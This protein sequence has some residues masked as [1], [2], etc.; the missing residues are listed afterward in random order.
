MTATAGR[1]LGIIAQTMLTMTG[2][3]TMLS[4]SRWAGD[5]GSYR[6]IQRFFATKI[7]WSQLLVK[8]FQTHLFNAEHDYILAGDETVVSKSGTETFGID[9]YFSGL[10]GKVIRGLSFFVF[11]L[12]DTTERKSSPLVVRQIV[13]SEAEKKLLKERRKK[14]PK[15]V[16][17][18]KGR[19]KGSLNKDKNELKLSPELWRIN[20]LL[21]TLV[22][23]LRE[24]VKI[25]YLAMDGH[26][27]HNQAV[28]MAR[29]ND[30]HLISKMRKDA[31]LFEKYEGKY[32]GRGAKKK[33]GARL[34]YDLIPP[35]Y[36]QKSERENEIITNYYQGRFLHQGFGC[37]LQVVIIVKIDLRRQKTGHATL[38]SSDIELSWEKLVDYYSLRFQ[39]EFNFRDAKQHFGLEDFMTTTEIGVENAANMAFL[40]VNLSAKLIKTQGATSVGINDLK[41]RYRGEKYAL[42]TIKLI[43]PKAERILIERVKEA[44]SRIGSIHRQ[45]YSV[46]SA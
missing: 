32:G 36:L 3:M 10:K 25:R 12:V 44:I 15:K 7:V 35:K 14:C 2:R 26:F 5:G 20:E 34:N 6:T 22:K 41:S 42:E 40:M 11:S 17:G 1:Q 37:E 45:K 27:G 23:L 4:L 13:R 43:Q 21:K 33:Y 16:K 24:F 29:A 31:K 46:S 9:R 18:V 30:L 8:F 38:F 19:T 28:L 39:I